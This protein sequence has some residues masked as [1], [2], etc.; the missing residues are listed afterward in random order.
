VAEEDVG[1]ATAARAVAEARKR[2]SGRLR[3]RDAAGEAGVAGTDAV[4][5]RPE[6]AVSVVFAVFMVGTDGWFL[7]LLRFEKKVALGVVVLKQ[8]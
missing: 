3:Q 4:E 5:T 7:S 8:K 6:T 2:I 1:K